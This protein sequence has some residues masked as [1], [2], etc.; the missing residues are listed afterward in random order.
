MNGVSTYSSPAPRDEGQGGHSHAPHEAQGQAHGRG[1][2]DVGQSSLNLE[3]SGERWKE[4]EEV[5][6]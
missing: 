5:F 2:T 3:I 4:E 1:T 6:W